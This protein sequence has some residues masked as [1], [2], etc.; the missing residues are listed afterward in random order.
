MLVAV[1]PLEVA[2]SI[3]PL[4]CKGPQPDQCFQTSP[5]QFGGLIQGVIIKSPSLQKNWPQTSFSSNFGDKLS[6]ILSF[7]FPQRLHCYL[8]FHCSYLYNYYNYSRTYL[9]QQILSFSILIVRFNIISL[10]C[11]H[12]SKREQGGVKAGPKTG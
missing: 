4:V 9:V 5:D 7:I 2:V 10:L 12:H 8:Y 3:L 6:F 1:E 11:R